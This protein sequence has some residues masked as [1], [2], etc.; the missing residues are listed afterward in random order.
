MGNAHGGF[1]LPGHPGGSD[2]KKDKKKE[3]KPLEAAPPSHVGRRKKPKGA[4]GATKLP[5]VTP[6]TKCRMR[7]LKLERVKDYLLLE[8]E[9]I[10][11]QEQ[12]KPA[13]ERNEVGYFCSLGSV[14]EVSRVDELRGSP[15]S[16][17]TLEELIDDQHAIVSSSIGP[18]YYVNILSF[19][20]KDLLEPGCSVLL[21]N[22]TSSI[23][24]ILSDEV[25]PLISVMKVEKAPLETYGDI[26][27][28]EKQ[29]QVLVTD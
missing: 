9:Y 1:N 18:E 3:K 17:G 14:E 21:H 6:V 4:I 11:N 16:V 5:N 22:K 24:G 20:D 15:L 19:V 8:E 29:I 7:L 25:D 28:L 27:G 23:V 12:H 26:G 10:S 2:D 13:E